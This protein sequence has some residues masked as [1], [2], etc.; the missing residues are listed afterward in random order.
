MSINVRQPWIKK[1]LVNLRLGIG[2]VKQVKQTLTLHQPTLELPG[3]SKQSRF[4]LLFLSIKKV[5]KNILLKK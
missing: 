2:Q 1:E 5:L 3:L 4:D